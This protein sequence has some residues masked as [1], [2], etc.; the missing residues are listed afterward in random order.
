[1]VA[2]YFGRKLSYTDAVHAC[3]LTPEGASMTSMAEAAERLGFRTLVARV[4]VRYLNRIPLPCIA[5]WNKSHYVVIENVTWRHVRVADPLNG[6]Q[7]LTRSE[8][9][10]QWAGDST[11]GAVLV[12]EPG[13]AGRHEGV[14]R[15][16]GLSR[17]LPYLSG[18]RLQIAQVLASI[19]LGS[20][21]QLM[22]AYTTR[23]LVDVA[24]QLRSVQFVYI[25]IGAQL[26]IFLCRAFNDFLRSWM[27]A[28]IS[29]ATNFAM[30]ADFLKT[31]LALPF[32]SFEHKPIGDTLQRIGDNNRIQSFLT[33]SIVSGAASVGN[34]VIFGVALLL[35]NTTIAGVFLGTSALLAIWMAVY[36]PKRKRLDNAR[37]EQSSRSQTA[38]VQMLSGARDIRLASAERSKRE[39]WENLQAK[40]FDLSLT[41]LTLNQQ[42]QGGAMAINQLRNLVISCI[43]ASEVIHGNMTLGTMFAI[44]YMVGALGGPIDQMVSLFQAAQDA[45]ISADRVSA[46]HADFVETQPAAAVAA[47]RGT[48]IELEGLSFRYDGGRRNVL[49]S[50]SLHVPSGTHL[51]IVGPSG[52]GKTTLL[53]LITKLYTP[54]AGDIRVGG[55]SL[56]QIDTHAWLKRCGVVSQDGFLFSDSLAANIALGYEEIDWIRLRHAAEVALLGTVVGRLPDGLNTRVGQYGHDLSAGERQR[57]LIARALYR[58]PDVFM[59]DEATSALDGGIERELLSNLQRELKGRTVITIAHRLSTVRSADRI[60]M[61]DR[62]VIVESGNHNDLV[63]ARSGYYDLVRNQIEVA[64]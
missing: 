33:T 32:Q 5:H 26:A 31:I 7:T 10:S 60:A 42:M 2:E 15:Q 62:G 43:A 13:D 1:M 49:E 47:P 30:I 35:L 36:V 22:L 12:V 27:T 40:Q 11:E 21:I 54:A 14:P 29:S 34:F 19:L 44:T 20:F 53:K 37:F 46:I 17:F 3:S 64:S 6:R 63:S 56:S 16:T 24:I 38:L 8:F 23:A 39:Q 25:V 50:L 9:V 61:I 51:A 41:G 55:V 4:A 48:D 18:R 59:F 28:H 58:T 45:K 52:S 57:V